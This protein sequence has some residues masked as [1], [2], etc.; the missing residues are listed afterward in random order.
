MSG[1]SLYHFENL[2]SSVDLMPVP[3][4]SPGN[5]PLTLPGTEIWKHEKDEGGGKEVKE[6]RWEAVKPRERM[7]M[8]GEGRK[9][10]RA[11]K[12]KR[13]REEEGVW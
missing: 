9:R 12:K 1:A 5:T 4:S 7:R 3:R 11:G 8:G 6:E 10:K 2:L 13:C